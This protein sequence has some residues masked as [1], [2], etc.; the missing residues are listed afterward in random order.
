MPHL[1]NMWPEWDGDERWWIHP[2]AERVQPVGVL[3]LRVVADRARGGG[4]RLRAR[5]A[6]AEPLVFMHGIS[7]LL[8]TGGCWSCS[9]R[10]TG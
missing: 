4:T 9:L 8:R 6:D 1:R 2:L 7:G 3:N 10:D 5:A